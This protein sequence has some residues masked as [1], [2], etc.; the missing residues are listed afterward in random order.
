M[1]ASF[2]D[3]TMGLAPSAQGKGLGTRMLELVLERIRAENVA[4]KGDEEGRR[5]GQGIEILYLMVREDNRAA[6]ALY[7][8]LGFEQVAVLHKDTKISDDLYYDGIMM[9]LFL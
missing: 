9:R 5:K 7:R 3:L 2:P 8:K 1:V 4:L 6:I